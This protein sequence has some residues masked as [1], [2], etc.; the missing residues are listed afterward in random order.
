MQEQHSSCTWWCPILVDPKCKN[1]IFSLQWMIPH[2][3][4]KWP[5]SKKSLEQLIDWSPYHS[6][7]FFAQMSDP[8]QKN[9]TE[10]IHLKS[11][12]ELSLPV[13]CLLITIQ[14]VLLDVWYKELYNLWSLHLCFWNIKKFCK[15]LVGAPNHHSKWTKNEENMRR[16]S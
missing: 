1:R 16:R 11:F 7:H 5:I 14:Q 9:S 13:K 3:W 2:S 4:T 10:M 12:V 15:A 8:Y 6:S